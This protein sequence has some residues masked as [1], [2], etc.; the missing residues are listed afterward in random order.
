MRAGKCLSVGVFVVTVQAG[1]GSGGETSPASSAGAWGNGGAGGTIAGANG[2]SGPLGSGG[3]PTDT[4]STSGN[5]GGGA[6]GQGGGGR[7][8]PPAG[9]FNGPPITAPPDEWTWVPVAGAKCR[10]GTDT[11]FAVRLHAGSSKVFIY[12]EGGGACFNGL[13]CGTNPSAF[14]KLSFEAWKGTL[15]ALGIFDTKTAENPVRDWN[16]IYVPYCTGD[17]HGGDGEDVDV[18]GF[19]NPKGQQFVGYRN[20]ERYLSRIVPTFAFAT[21]VLLTG[22]SAGGFG[23]AYN[24]DRIASAFCPLPV[25]LIDDSGPPMADAYLVPCLQKQWRD[26]WN[27]EGTLPKDC[28]DCIDSA[29]GGIA[30]YAKYIAAQWPK[31]KLGLISSTRDSTIS[32][33]FGF[34]ANDCGLPIPMSGDTY[35][36]GLTDL[37]DHYLSSSGRWGTYFVDSTTHTYLAGPGFYLTKVNGKKLSTWVAEMLA[38]EPSDIGP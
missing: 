37:R 31:S 32:L 18:P 16:A 6:D 26:L 15:G 35:A 38:G 36:E 7:A 33:F 29:G 5:E 21:E 3:A 25:T 34:G 8:C 19:G 24:Y 1:C 2:S 28:A 27:L 14:G 12:L 22:V 13:S 30:N 20:I 17:I 4:S 23:A 9:P 10:D 11:G